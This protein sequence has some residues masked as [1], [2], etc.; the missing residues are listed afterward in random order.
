MEA[1]SLT[2]PST[3]LALGAAAKALFYGPLPSSRQH[4]GGRRRLGRASKIYLDEDESAAFGEW[5]YLTMRGEP[6]GQ[7]AWSE[8]AAQGHTGGEGLAQGDTGGEGLE[9]GDTGGEGL[10]PGDT[11]GE[12]NAGAGGGDGGGGGGDGVVGGLGGSGRASAWGQNAWNSISESGMK[13][14][15]ETE[16][17]VGPTFA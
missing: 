17:Q 15:S 12:G 1:S 9:P 16:A 6:S 4:D 13:F 7:A 3:G 2:Y 8:W 10:E 11:G 5:A 14:A